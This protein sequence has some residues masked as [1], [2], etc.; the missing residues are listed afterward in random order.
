MSHAAFSPMVLRHG[1]Y[2]TS[3]LE[4]AQ[5]SDD[6]DERMTT[7]FRV[8]KDRYTGNATG[9]TIALGYD[10]KTGL[11]FDKDAPFVDETTGQEEAF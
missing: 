6:A 7:T 3:G 11:L 10:E 1:S 8:L 4:R 5:Q 9:K 2:S